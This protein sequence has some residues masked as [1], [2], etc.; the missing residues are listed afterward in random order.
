MGAL[1]D[2]A[3]CS[4]TRFDQLSQPRFDLAGNVRSPSPLTGR[5][6]PTSTIQ[7]SRRY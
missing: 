2:A 5:D 6:R 7:R 3:F 4:A 1:D